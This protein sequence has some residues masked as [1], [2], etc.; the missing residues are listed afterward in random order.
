MLQAQPSGCPVG[1]GVV[2]KRRFRT[3]LQRSQCNSPALSGVLTR[4]TLRQEVW[5][6]WFGAHRSLQNKKVF[7]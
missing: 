6:N 4:S 1:P 5:A 3:T 7:V 2:P